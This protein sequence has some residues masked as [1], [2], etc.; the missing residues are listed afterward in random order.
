MITFRKAHPSLGRSRFWREDIRWYGSGSKVDPSHH[1]YVLAYCLSGASQEDRDIYVMINA[2]WKNLDFTIQEA[3]A[4]EWLRVVDTALE[5]PD[6]IAVPGHEVPV[7]NLSYTVKS[8]SI[9]I[10]IRS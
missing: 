9:V 6:D 2:Y 10:L 5:S 8:R 4:G 3:A 1:T 7:N